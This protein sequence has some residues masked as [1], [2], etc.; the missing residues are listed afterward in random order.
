MSLEDLVNVSKCPTCDNM[1]PVGRLRP[2]RP[3]KCDSCKRKE[4]RLRQII[5]GKRW[6]ARTHK[7]NCIKCGGEI[8]YIRGWRKEV[9]IDCQAIIKMKYLDQRCIYCDTVLDDLN[10]KFCDRR[11]QQKTLYIVN[12]R[13]KKCG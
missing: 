7:K 5:K 10:K 13:K 3:R 8:P 11:C 12:G 6:Y 2:E 4:S 9:C 1:V